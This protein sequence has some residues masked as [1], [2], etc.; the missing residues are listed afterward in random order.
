MADSGYLMEGSP[1]VDPIPELWDD[2]DVV[3]QRFHGMTPFAGTELDWILKS[4]GAKTLVVTGVSLNRG[5]TGTVIEAVNYGYQVVIPRDCVVG[6]P[7]GYGD[8]VLEHTLAALAWLTD[9]AAL[10]RVWSAD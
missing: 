4:L 2:R 5:V 10:A 8:Q 1:D 7:A 9:A 6:Y 3:L